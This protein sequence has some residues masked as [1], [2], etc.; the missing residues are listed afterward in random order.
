MSSRASP[1]A[2]LR[3][4]GIAALNDAQLKALIVDKSLWGREHRFRDQVQDHLQRLRITV[5]TTR[6]L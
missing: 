2:D 5:P 4:Q 1:V 3:K 6:F